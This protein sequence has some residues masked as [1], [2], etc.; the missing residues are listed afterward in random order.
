MNTVSTKASVG[1]AHSK[2]ILFGEHAVVYGK[3][4]IAIPFPLK[5]RSIVEEFEG[6]I[7]LESEFYTGSID[8]IP[9]KMQGISACIKA[10][11]D[12]LKMPFYGLRIKIDSLIPIGRGLGSS[13]AIAIAIVRGL[14]SFYGQE[15]SKKQLFSLVNIAEKHAHGNPSG[16]DMVAE[17]S[18]C[19]IWFKKGNKAVSI[20]AGGPLFIVVAD[21]GRIG[22]TRKAV[23]NVR[24]KYNIEPKKVYKSLDEI[25]KISNKAREA[26]SKGDMYLLGELMDR[27]QKE[28]TYIGVS[29]KGL[30]KLIESAKDSSALGAKLTGGG[31]GGCVMALAENLE[32]AKVIAKDLK[33]AGAVK[34]WYFST[35]EKIL[36]TIGGAR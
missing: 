4:A 21:T 32:H 24:K 16:I 25:E 22:N 30:D 26:L 34:C 15:L 31:L 29:D 33:R 5:V 28:L 19:A 11:I 12:Y 18:E 36:Y 20:I 7:I 17:S 14:F 3:P 1:Y 6:P 23:E 35:E 2:L 9:E 8:N 13:A 27:N 10:T